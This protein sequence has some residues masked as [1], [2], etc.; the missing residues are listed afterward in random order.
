MAWQSTTQLWRISSFVLGLLALV[1]QCRVAAAERFD[2][3]RTLKQL[4]YEVVELRRTGD[5]HLF[6]F[7]KV[8]GRKRS[9][10][11]D[12]GWSFTTIS[13]N[14]ATRLTE[15]NRIAQLTLGRVMLTN[16]T[17]V[18]QDLRV[19][20]QP[21]SYDVVL[22]CDF[23]RQHHA[24][25][26]CAGR[27]LYLRNEALPALQQNELKRTM[28]A[29]G[30][31]KVEMKPRE[32][33]ALTCPGQVADHAMEWLVDSGA[34]WSCL[35]AQLA[36]S[37]KLR[38]LPT[39]NRMSGPAANGARNFTVANL[40]SWRLDALP[41]PETSVAVFSLKEWGLG[42][43]GKLFRD[44][45]GILGGAELLKLRAVIDCGGL[46]LWLQPR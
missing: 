13:T 27:R 31:G 21:T 36:K 30:F 16:E 43:E 35:D 45:G 12:T 2:L 3:G 26:D 14:T 7:G 1:W 38:A 8:D 41:L 5:H 20:G 22:G 29:A 9:C 23:L 17:V 6:L 10:L 25:I 34:M 39:L 15:T 24:I 4:G 28:A 32:P 42:P 40:Q 33:G 19:N 18:V 46:K 37:L 11:V 44:V